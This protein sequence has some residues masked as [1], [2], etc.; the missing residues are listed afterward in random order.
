VLNKYS[1]NQPRSIPLTRIQIHPGVIMYDD[2]QPLVAA[3]GAPIS[4]SS[5]G[6]WGQLYRAGKY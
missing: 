3:D 2:L 4:A 6:T 5:P 1:Y